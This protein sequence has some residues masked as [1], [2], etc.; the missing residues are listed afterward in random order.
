MSKK[1]TYEGGPR[2]GE[3]SEAE[4]SDFP[5]IYPGGEYQWSGLSH[6]STG[7]GDPDGP[8]RDA[9]LATAVWSEKEA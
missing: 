1:F 3:K 8:L 9:N 7:A 6:S 2:N 4:E 5:Q